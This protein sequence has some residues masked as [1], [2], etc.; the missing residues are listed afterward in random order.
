MVLFDQKKLLSE[1]KNLLKGPRFRLFTALSMPTAWLAGLK[2]IQLDDNLCITSL[3]GGWRSQNPF[4]TMYWAVQG[5][6]AELS[7]GASAFALSKSMSEK[8]RMF[9]IGTEATFT[10]RAKGKIIFTCK[11][12]S[13]T[14]DAIKES[15]LT[16]KSVECDLVSV[17]TDK[18]GDVVSEWVFKW[19]FLVIEGE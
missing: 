12:N 11:D 4:N 19:N 7:T 16:G 9:V 6:G 13:K 1:Y 18:S 8:L 3:P 2:I 5:M 17:A 15:I 14:R 10:K